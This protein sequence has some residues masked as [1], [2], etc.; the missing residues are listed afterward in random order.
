MWDD[1]NKKQNED[2]MIQL[3]FYSRNLYNKSTRIAV[4]KIIVIVINIILSLI[5]KDTVY[6]S[7]AFFSAFT[8]LEIYENFC[9]KNAA[10]ARNI[11]DNILFGFKQSD[12]E[13]EIKEKAYSLC[14]RHKKEYEIQKENLGTDNPPGL[15]NW[16]SEK[17]GNG[18][19]EIVF[20]CQ[21]ENTEWDKKITIIDL[22]IFMAVLIAVAVLVIFKYYNKE[23]SELISVILVGIELVYEIIKRFK[24]YSVHNKIIS[25]RECL[26]NQYSKDKIKK[27][28][29]IFLQSSIEKRREMDLVPLNFIHKKITNYMHDLINKVNK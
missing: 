8:I 20:K 13:E 16:Y 24:L 12:Y 25:I 15:R 21:I 6:L 2:D 28:D 29:L 1:I 17:K 23:L 19:N 4:L 26:I 11:F 3:L 18:K 5:Q 14:K 10:K 22:K 27:D 9:V 7:S